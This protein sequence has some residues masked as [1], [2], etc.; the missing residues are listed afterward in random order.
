MKRK[1]RAKRDEKN[2]GF[3]L[4]D[5]TPEYGFVPMSHS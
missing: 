3:T 4:L 2:G 5:M 1:G